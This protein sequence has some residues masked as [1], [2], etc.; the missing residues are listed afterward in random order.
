MAANVPPS[1]GSGLWTLVSGT[2]TITTPT[3]Y[4]TTITGVPLGQSALVRWT[5]NNGACST[6][7]SDTARLFNDAPVTATAGADQSLC[8]NSTFTMA[9]NTP[10]VGA[11]VWTVVSGSGA[12]TN[13]MKGPKAQGGG[14]FHLK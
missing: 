5:V 9:A 14:C 8:N 4:N 3:A 7:A 1:S 6:P 13:I 11:G 10:S 2:A 12:I